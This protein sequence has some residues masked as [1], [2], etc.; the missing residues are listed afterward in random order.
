MYLPKLQ[1][2]HVLLEILYANCKDAPISDAVQLVCKNWY[3]MTSSFWFV[4]FESKS[5]CNKI[6]Q[7]KNPAVAVIVEVLSNKIIGQ[8]QLVATQ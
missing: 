8:L 5:K 3:N 4:D 2:V 1:C 6:L 7:K